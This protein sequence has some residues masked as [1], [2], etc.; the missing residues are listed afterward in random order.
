[1]THVSIFWRTTKCHPYHNTI[2]F[3]II[4][5]RYRFYCRG[6]QNFLMLHQLILNLIKVIWSAIMHSF[7]S[8]AEETTYIRSACVLKGSVQRKLMPRLLYMIR[9]LFSRRWTAENKIV[10]FLKGQLTIYIKPLQR[11]VTVLCKGRNIF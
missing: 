8:S 5:S 1:M 9:K 7:K 4:Q 2:L 10:T 3:Y 6:D 11:T